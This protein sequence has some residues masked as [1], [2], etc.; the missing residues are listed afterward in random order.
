MVMVTQVSGYYLFFWAQFFLEKNQYKIKILR[1]IIENQNRKFPT[2]FFGFFV[3]FKFE[4]N[5]FRFQISKN[6]LKILKFTKNS[7]KSTTIP[8][9]RK[10]S[11]Q[12][13]EK[14]IEMY[15]KSIKNSFNAQPAE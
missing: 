11:A 4:K 1:R 15:E 5:S 3:F 7:K 14:F 12:F 10:K 8:L 2:I 9:K 13:I 6:P